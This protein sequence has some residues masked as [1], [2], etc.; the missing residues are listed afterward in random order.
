MKD[1]RKYIYD[2]PVNYIKPD[3]ILSSPEYTL[4]HDEIQNAIIHRN[5]NGLGSAVK[6][7]GKRYFF[8]KKLFDEWVNKD[9]RNSHATKD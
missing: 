5:T 8:D 7:V 6:Q 1:R 4:A 3:E 2:Y 9:K